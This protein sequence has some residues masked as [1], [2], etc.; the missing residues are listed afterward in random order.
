MQQTLPTT[1]FHRNHPFALE[2]IVAD[3]IG[4]FPDFT[5]NAKLDANHEDKAKST[6]PNANFDYRDSYQI[7]ARDSRY[8]DRTTGLSQ[9]YKM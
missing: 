6:D 3:D 4:K 8:C 5:L 2:V 9:A 1:R 7:D